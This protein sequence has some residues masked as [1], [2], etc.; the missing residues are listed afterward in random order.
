MKA[1]R[2]VVASEL[3]L[4]LA[5]QQFLAPYARILRYGADE[6]VQYAGTVPTAMAFIVAGSVQ[7]TVTDAD[8][9]VLPF[10]T[11]NEG[12]FIGITALTRQPNLAGA[13]AL[14]EVT[15][16]EIDRE[17]LEKIVMDKPTLLQDLGRLID[18]RQNK[19][20]STRRERGKAV[21]AVAPG[22]LSPDTLG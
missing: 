8:G 12:S 19:A 22:R 16:L 10:A 14:E 18:E 7:L 3:R 1:L 4:T 21:T 9:A 11:L 2:T 5:D 20:R 6:I 15:A 13:Y 17:H